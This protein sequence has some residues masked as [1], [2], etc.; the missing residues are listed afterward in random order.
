ML[1]N[2][3]SLDIKRAEIN[4]IYSFIPVC[5]FTFSK[6]HKI[7]EV[8]H[9]N[10]YV[11]PDLSLLKKMFPNSTMENPKERRGGLSAYLALQHNIGSESLS[12]LKCQLFQVKDGKPILEDGKP[13]L[14]VTLKPILRFFPTGCSC[15][16]SVWINKENEN[17]KINTLDIQKILHLVG[18]IDNHEAS[19]KL[20]VDSNDE[21]PYF[22]KELF[23]SIFDLHRILVSE[24][25]K[26]WHGIVKKII[27]DSGKSSL[28][29]DY[30]TNSDPYNPHIK[31]LCRE[32]LL[33]H[34]GPI[35]KKEFEDDALVT[36]LLD[37]KIIK[38]NVE[39]HFYAFFID[40]L[41][42][43]DKLS[44]HLSQKSFNENEK[45]K[46]LSVWRQCHKPVPEPQYP[47]LM[48]NLELNERN[49]FCESFYNKDGA[50]SY[51]NKQ[52]A[53]RKYEDL[54]APLIYRSPIDDIS[55]WETEPAYLYSSDTGGRK[56]FYNMFLNSKF[57]VH[58]TRRSI[59]TIANSFNENPAIFVLPTLKDISE[60]THSRW[61][62][63]VILNKM[64]DNLIRRFSYN[65]IDAREK[66]QNMISL[67][68]MSSCCL[69]DPSI[70]TVSGNALRE[71]HDDIVNTFKLKELADTLLVK[72]NL[73][74]KT[75]TRTTE[76]NFYSVF[77]T[78]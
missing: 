35:N 2:K 8:F 42:N 11:F 12:E 58:I 19:Y 4:F 31:T 70:Y 13:V 24:K 54:I 29:K 23:Y 34:N 60:I 44:E 74:E 47:W 6:D 59:L 73:L 52:K 40:S 25:E 77:P 17:Q 69:E 63:L 78:S 33:I 41:M 1:N 68:N 64:T 22:K 21:Y 26:E 75:Y 38:E 61:Q 76:K 62:T 16:L 3:L 20:K 7:D 15:N 39:D 27:Q 50:I 18:N 71:I 53:I 67:F 36:K 56:G 30:T 5:N 9:N 28:S 32:Y 43:E 65:T 72:I 45:E 66:L 37:K 51:K 57:F 10:N 14:K 49:V 48:I 55:S 46:V